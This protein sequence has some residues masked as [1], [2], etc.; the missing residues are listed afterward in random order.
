M[1]LIHKQVLHKTFGEGKI[2]A[3]SDSMIEVN[4]LSGTKKFAFPDAFGRFLTL[5]DKSAAKSVEAFQEKLE[6]R[7]QKERE[8]ERQELEH[9]ILQERLLGKPRQSPRSQIAFWCMEEELEKVFS[10]WRI[11][12]GTVQSGASKGTPKR[13][14]SLRQNSACLLTSRSSDQLERNRIILGVYMVSENFMGAKCDD[15]IIPAHPKFRL[16]LSPQESQRMLF[17]NYYTNENYPKNI[18]WNSGRYRYFNNEWMAQ[19][20]RDILSLKKGTEDETL[21]QEFYDHFCHINH[22]DQNTLPQPNGSLK[23]I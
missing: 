20:L 23:G 10:E 5:L 17:W 13:P 16:V 6:E 9:F 7:R 11:F 4:F 12:T 21:M 22:I 15:G 14:A 8:L 1:N 3:Q 19:I 18:T 2:V